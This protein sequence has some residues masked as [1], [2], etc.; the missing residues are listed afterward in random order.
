MPQSQS[1]LETVNAR[2]YLTQLAKHF[3]HKIT[4]EDTPQG[5]RCDFAAATAW[6][7]ADDAGL[8]MRI[9]ATDD[10]GLSRGQHVIE[11]H[12]LRFAFRELPAPLVWTAA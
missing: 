5:T 4:I 10:Q 1:R 6:L 7:N 3:G 2:R 11:D 12:L 9:E 8:S